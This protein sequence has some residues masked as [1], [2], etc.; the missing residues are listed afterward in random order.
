ML[1]IGESGGRLGDD[2]DAY[3]RSRDLEAGSSDAFPDVAR[4]S[5]ETLFRVNLVTFGA[6]A[7]EL[8]DA[9]LIELDRFVGDDSR[10]DYRICRIDAEPQVREVGGGEITVWRGEVLATVFRDREAFFR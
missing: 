6:N 8:H 9:A 1:R 10:L 5:F 4:S 3:E 7:D 2:P